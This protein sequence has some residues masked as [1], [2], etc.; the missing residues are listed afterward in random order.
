MV[1]EGLLYTKDHEWARIDADVATIGITDYAQQMLGELV[2][3][4]LPAIGKEF[5]GH[6][7]LAIVE[8]TKAANDIYSPVAGKVIEVNGEL[9]SQP[10]LINQDCY[11]AG[12][13]C[14]LQITDTKS[15]ENLMDSK[16]Y[17]EYVG[18]L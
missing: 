7:E 6:D 8:S 14:K 5:A 3:V 12:W 10:E 13:I 17:E 18:G 11:N 1:I 4:E 9:E 16:R 15:V 2:F